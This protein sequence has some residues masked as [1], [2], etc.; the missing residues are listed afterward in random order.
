MTRLRPAP[1]LVAA[2]LCCLALIVIALRWPRVVAAGW[3]TGFLFVSGVPI[4]SLGWL[5]IHWLTGGRWGA[6]LAPVFRPAA[7]S[8]PSLI[9]LAIPLMIAVPAL[10]PW[11]HAPDAVKPSVLA[12]YLNVPLFVVRTAI[13]LLGLTVLALLPATAWQRRSITLAAIGLIFYGV[14]MTFAGID[15]AL[16]L[17]PPFVSTSFGVTMIATQLLS[18]LAFA[19]LAG[20]PADAS[21]RHDLA[22]LMLALCLAVLY[23]NFMAFVVLWY[24]DVPGKIFWLA[25]RDAA[26]W[27][28]LTLLALL[29]G[30]IAPSLALMMARIRESR[31][32]LQI[33]AVAIL[34]GVALYDAILI[35]PAFGAWALAAGA[36]ASVGIACFLLALLAMP[37]SQRLRSRA[38][39][40]N[41]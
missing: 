36:I 16:A 4:G 5:L 3:L 39:A 2:A 23:L 13:V 1:L 11:L 35:A 33:V 15:W 26:P 40:A 24:G 7:T 31:A 27:S 14:A 29:L 17:E 30:T 18:T 37:W 8:M 38:E 10:Y 9:V 21:G 22:G 41:G 6:Q 19:A 32:A 12:L 34:I 20:C 25:Q 28:W